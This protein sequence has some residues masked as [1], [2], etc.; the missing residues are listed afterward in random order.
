ML[1]NLLNWPYAFTIL[2]PFQTLYMT[3]DN[4]R[5]WDKLMENV[6]K[7]YWGN[8]DVGECCDTGGTIYAT[9][10]GAEDSILHQSK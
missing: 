7:V 8:P 6:E 2:I 10:G 5:N 4:G 1:K 9:E 3:K